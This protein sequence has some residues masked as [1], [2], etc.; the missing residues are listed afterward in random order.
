MHT[1]V[2]ADLYIFISICLYKVNFGDYYFGGLSPLIPFTVIPVGDFCG[3][4]KNSL[5]LTK[6]NCVMFILIDTHNY[7][8][9]NIFLL[10][11]LYNYR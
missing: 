8:L 9:L 2:N 4:V 1:K 6:L 3:T 7:V 11:C 5:T 10:F